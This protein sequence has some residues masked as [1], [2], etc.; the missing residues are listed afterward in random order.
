MYVMR[1]FDEGRS[2][3]GPSEADFLANTISRVFSD[4]E[5][6]I[7]YQIYKLV[8]N[9]QLE[10]A[11]DAFDRVITQCRMLGRK[12]NS[13]HAASLTGKGMALLE[14]GQASETVTCE[15]EALAIQ[16]MN[17]L[18]T[19][20]LADAHALL[21]ARED[22]LR[23]YDETLALREQH[24]YECALVL[25]YHVTKKKASVVA[26]G[27]DLKQAIALVNRF[28]DIG[29]N[30]MDG[31][32]ALQ[33]RALYHSLAGHWKEACDDYS[34]AYHI[35]GSA[36]VRASLMEACLMIEDLTRVLAI[37]KDD[38]LET[39]L[40]TGYGVICEYFAAV[41]RFLA[42]AKEQSV[43][44]C[45]D[46]C[47]RA[48]APAIDWDFG[49]MNERLKQRIDTP[50]LAFLESVQEWLKGKV[51]ADACIA[52]ALAIGTGISNAT[53]DKQAFDM[54]EARRVARLMHGE[55]LAIP[56]EVTDEQFKIQSTVIGDHLQYK[57]I[58]SIGGHPRSLAILLESPR[59]FRHPD[60]A[61]GFEK[62]RVYKEMAAIMDAVCR[63]WDKYSKF[64]KNRAHIEMFGD[65]S[66]SKEWL[67]PGGRTWTFSESVPPEKRDMLKKMLGDPF[68]PRP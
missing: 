26:A 21:G 13:M 10:P 65:T 24:E 20:A 33:T 23:W 61:E 62:T 7:F 6:A 27:G 32:D 11:I 45:V 53:T 31:A 48:P 68:S 52:A 51:E 17:P 64:L 35:N 58:A 47:K 22:A 43:Q 30:F 46:M 41:E 50:G 38:K 40:I 29:E 67:T 54:V 63:V 66:A 5:G 49:P 2:Q 4:A 12:A 39:D 15:K 14:L 9:G 59:L 8:E 37:V 36:F 19:L 28:A 18:A 42:G 25:P 16:S 1:K 57:G 56:F 34:R 44:A 55:I 60:E 3:G